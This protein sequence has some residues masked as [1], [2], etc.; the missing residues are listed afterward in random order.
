M[1]ENF[2]LP[3]F[4]KCAKFYTRESFYVY[5]I[6]AYFHITP[7]TEAIKLDKYFEIT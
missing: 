2:Q 1:H 4:Q 3:T 7:H 5:D 6:S